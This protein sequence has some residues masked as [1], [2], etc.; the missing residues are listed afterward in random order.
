ME[1]I[2]TSCRCTSCEENKDGE[3]KKLNSRF[4]D[5]NN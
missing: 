3:C 4:I 5:Y 2:D 1:D